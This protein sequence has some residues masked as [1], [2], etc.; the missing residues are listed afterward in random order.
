MDQSI[1][2]YDFS[3]ISVLVAEHNSY[4]RQTMRS[5]LRTFNIGQI[6]EARTPDHAWDAF[7]LHKPDVV[8]ADWA[9]GFDGMGLLKQIRRD[10]DSPNPFVPVIIVTSM[11]DKEH[12]LTARD[13]GMTEFL[14]KPFS[15]K[16]IYLRL[17]IIAEQPRSFVRTGNFF[18]PDRRR[19]QI[20]VDENRR[21]KGRNDNGD[22]GAES[23]EREEIA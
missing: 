9:P 21:E 4:M 5:I 2:A 17:R 14:A 6:E 20:H 1:K 15:P 10:E 8:F 7:K 19:R 23:R 16:L 18:G 3:D 13:L 11:S 22:S 12:V